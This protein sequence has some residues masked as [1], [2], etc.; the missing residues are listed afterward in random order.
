MAF[1][2]AIGLPTTPWLTCALHP[3]TT[4]LSGAPMAAQTIQPDLLVAV[5]RR[6]RRSLG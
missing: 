4:A 6:L 5:L 1:D 3:T 2:Q